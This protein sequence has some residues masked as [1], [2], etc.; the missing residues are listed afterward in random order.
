MSKQTACYIM[1]QGLGHLKEFVVGLCRCHDR[2]MTMAKLVKHLKQ[3]QAVI[4]SDQFAYST[5]S[6]RASFVTGALRTINSTDRETLKGILLMP[7]VCQC[8]NVNDSGKLTIL[9]CS[10]SWWTCIC[11][12]FEQPAASSNS[13]VLLK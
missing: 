8:L 11:L 5:A 13:V 6:A 9:T 7:H 1:Q 2:G 4:L 12:A 3:N 10:T